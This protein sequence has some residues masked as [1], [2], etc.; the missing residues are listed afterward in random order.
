MSLHGA[1]NFRG[2]ISKNG[3]Y[4]LYG[5]A[6]SVTTL[7]EGDDGNRCP[8]ETPT[9]T[10]TSCAEASTNKL[11]FS[12]SSSKSVTDPI[13]YCDSYNT[14]RTF[15]TSYSEDGYYAVSTVED[16]MCKEDESTI[17]PDTNYELQF[18][19]DDKTGK[20]NWYCTQNPAPV[21]QYYCLPQNYYDPNNPDLREDLHTCHF[22][23]DTAVATKNQGYASL[24]ECGEKCNSYCS[25]TE[26][27]NVKCSLV[28]QDKYGVRPDVCEK[29]CG[30]YCKNAV[31]QKIIQNDPITNANINPDPNSCVGSVDENL[32]WQVYNLKQHVKGCFP[33][34][35]DKDWIQGCSS[36]FTDIN[37]FI[38]T[39]KYNAGNSLCGSVTD[40]SQHSDLSELKLNVTSPK[41]FV[42]I[43][44]YI[45]HSVGILPVGQGCYCEKKDDGSGD[46]TVKSYSG[47]NPASGCIKHNDTLGSFK[48]MDYTSAVKCSN[49]SKMITG[50]KGGRP[51]IFCKP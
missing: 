26:D 5:P 47:N 10:Y 33:K 28:D 48:D 43:P 21:S 32:P 35:L 25:N 40:I 6:G 16:Y 31:D 19:Y 42:P 18:A 13:Q 44:N 15:I 9:G 45:K 2:T 49:G 8:F 22:T 27:D 23:N 39:K 37:N 29:A 50:K 30:F 3:K 46:A 36:S 1:A 14:N 41:N 51:Y 17:S 38:G 11:D 4:K 20:S 24:A 12:C 7:R 34:I